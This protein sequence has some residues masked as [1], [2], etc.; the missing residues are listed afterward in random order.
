VHDGGS[1]RCGIV[2]FTVEGHAPT[3]VAEAAR[4]VGVNVSVTDRPAARLDLGGDRPTS[5]V[6]ASP[7]YYNTSDELSRL[8]EAVAGMPTG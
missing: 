1:R 6:R 4:A 2:T 5:V 8:A 3:E 7:H